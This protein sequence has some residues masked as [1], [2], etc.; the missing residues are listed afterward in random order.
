MGDRGDHK[1]S[2]GEAWLRLGHNQTEDYP[3][4]SGLDLYS[5]SKVRKPPSWPRSWPNFSLRLLCSHRNVWANL[6]LLGQPNTFLAQGS[7]VATRS[8][9]SSPRT[10]S[11]TSSPRCMAPSRRQT[12][13]PA[14]PRAPGSIAAARSTYED[15][16]RCVRNLLE[17]ELPVSRAASRPSTCSRT[18]RTLGGPPVGALGLGGRDSLYERGPWVLADQAVNVVLFVLK[19][20][21]R[22]AG[23]RGPRP[24][25]T[26]AMVIGVVKQL[27]HC[28]PPLQLLASGSIQYS[29]LGVAAALALKPLE[30][31]SEQPRRSQRR[32]RRC[33]R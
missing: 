32:R 6:Y 27:H 1:L 18:C 3:P 28:S 24:H 25:T 21:H 2:H 14:R 9:T 29:I 20:S 7:G 10:S 5:F 8:P 4:Q 33:R 31:M 23:R 12:S 19:F 16:A 17:V 13:R 15:V 22:V 26:P 30:A 11:S